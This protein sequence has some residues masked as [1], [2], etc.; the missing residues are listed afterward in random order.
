MRALASAPLKLFLEALV[1]LRH[2]F[3]ER[4]VGVPPLHGPIGLR[5]LESPTL[6][7]RA[8]SLGASFTR[9]ER[10]AVFIDDV[11]QLAVED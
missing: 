11:T 2:T 6:R 4:T 7:R 8:G 5:K 3:A 10:Q 1:G 9:T